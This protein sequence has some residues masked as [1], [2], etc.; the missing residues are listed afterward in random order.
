MILGR[1]DSLGLGVLA[2][3]APA[4]A[5]P[6]VTSFRL[7]TPAP[8]VPPARPC[9]RALAVAWLLLAMAFA[10]LV[11]AGPW[12]EQPGHRWHPLGTPLS[13]TGTHLLHRL[14]A[15]ATGIA[16][17]NHLADARSLTNH[18]LLNGSGVALGDVDGDGLADI[19]LAGLDGPNRLF[20]NRGGLRFERSLQP[21]LEAAGGDATGTVMADVDGDGDLDL[22]VAGVGRG[23]SLWRNNGKGAFEDAT[24]ESGLASMTGSMSMALADA[25]G[26]GDLDL[27]VANYRTS[28]VR[29]GFSLK[30]RT[31]RVDGRLVVTHVDGR[32]TT[33]PDLVGRFRIGP[34]GELLEDGEADAFCVNEGNGRFRRVSW[35]DGAFRDAAGR[36]LREPPFDWSLSV[37]FRDLDGDRRPDL[38][39]CGDLASPDRAWRNRGDGT[40]EAFPRD[41]FSVTSWF[42]MGID[43]GDLDRD[44]EDDLMVTDMRGRT[45]M[46]RQVQATT[47]AL[48]PKLPGLGAE[49]P[50]SPRN[51]LFR[52]MGSGRFEERAFASGVA[53]SDWSWAPVFLDVDLDGWDDVLV[54]TGFVRDVQDL[55]VAAELERERQRERIPEAEALR[56]RS[57]F[58]R[59]DQERLLFRNIGGWRF[60]DASKAW[61]FSERGIATGMALADLDGDGDLDVV[62]NE[63]NQAASVYR[64]DAEGGRVAVRLAGRGA[65]TRGVGA[66]IRVR[67]GAVPLQQQDIQAGGRYL[68]GDEPLRAFATG[69]RDARLRIEVLWRDGSESVVEEARGGRLYEVSQAGARLGAGD[70]SRPRAATPLLEDVSALL[71][72]RHVEADYDDFA[73]QPSLWRKQSQAGPAVAWGDLDADGRVDLVVGTGRGGSVVCFRNLGDGRIERWTNGLAR[74]T[75]RDV[76]GV[77]TWGASRDAVALIASMSNLEGEPGEPG[78]VLRLSPVTGKVADAVPPQESE[79]GALAM[80]DVDGDGDLDLLVAGRGVPGRYPEPGNTRLWLGSADG[81]V[82]DEAANQALSGAGMVQGATLADL[83]GDGYPE[84]ILAVEWGPVRIY[85]RGRTGP[86]REMTGE[87]GLAGATGL[88]FGV[89]VMDADSDGRLDIVASNWGTN[90]EWSG[91]SRG[92][93]RLHAGDIE[94]AGGMEML[95]GWTDSTGREWP[96]IHWGRASQALPTWAATWRSHREFAA[97]DVPA[98]LGDRAKGL[99]V[100]EA[101]TLESSI[102]LNRGGR[103][104]RR[105]LPFAAQSAPGMGLAVADFDGDGA[106]DVFV[107]QNF[108]ATDVESDA[109]NAGTGA[110]IRGDGRGGLEPMTWR[111]SGVFVREDQRGAAVADFDGDGRPDLAVGCN[112]GAVR[113]WRNRGGKP[114]LRV[115][116]EGP[117]GNREGIGA[118]VHWVSDGRRGPARAITRGSGYLGQDDAV[119]TLHGMG[120]PAGF[121][122]VSW[123]GGMT[124]RHGFAVGATEVRCVMGQGTKL[125]DHPK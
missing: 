65:N 8:H 102:F 29:D 119:V 118:V 60:E 103:F 67:G 32:P 19:F 116:L 53:A 15:E 80:A 39:V 100:L 26:D 89:A 64:N 81:W 48:R 47:H 7:R 49:W 50:Q 93:W 34:N 3:P 58:P 6:P 107:A 38:Y 77:L 12:N 109:A 31:G 94:G 123:P 44:G 106:E 61:G 121:V 115:R 4:L 25:D 46:Q 122:E 42:S 114:G 5:S 43:A 23:V 97:L 24:A 55:D 27:Y 21:L 110:V 51:T 54:G 10:R 45:P 72:H 16:F 28:T 113:L 62:V 30:L 74:R 22:L 37:L 125:Q 117:P 83:D 52:G 75:S 84:V 17:T 66:R 86:W 71:P 95:L 82:A 124:E 69:S 18:V 73:R 35:T 56:R 112:A 1:D 104:E 79:P 96:F 99:R 2:R 70:A 78:S 9:P 59:L 120:A 68:S 40:F 105:P 57:R 11:A 98:L 85:R 36:P 91:L 76:G 63:V 92:P 88:W 111:D 13:K 20:L 90:T 14:S 41:S 101:V 108:S 87:W 33:E